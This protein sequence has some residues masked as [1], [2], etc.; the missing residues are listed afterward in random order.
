MEAL[1]DA[2]GTNGAGALYWCGYGD[3]DIPDPVTRLLADARTHGKLAYYVPALGSNVIDHRS[4]D[5]EPPQYHEARRS[6]APTLRD[7]HPQIDRAHP[8]LAG[9]LQGAG[10]TRPTARSCASSSR[11]RI[12]SAGLLRPRYGQ[13][14]KV[15]RIR[16]FATLS[17]NARAL[18]CVAEGL[19]RA[20]D[21]S[22]RCGLPRFHPEM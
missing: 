2:C 14:R 1:H 8:T 13:Q 3:G 5:L 19:R 22:C 9:V 11:T 6:Q 10:A 12:V 15:M 7:L 16:R 21:G 18:A 4:T 17:R 20:L